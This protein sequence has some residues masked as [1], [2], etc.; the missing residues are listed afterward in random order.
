[1]ISDP[2]LFFSCLMSLL[3]DS[4]ELSTAV[5]ERN[6]LLPKGAFSE[7]IGDNRRAHA[8]MPGASGKFDMVFCPEGGPER[9]PALHVHF[10]KIARTSREAVESAIQKVF[11]PAEF[12]NSKNNK[13]EYVCYSSRRTPTRKIFILFDRAKLPETVSTLSGVFFE[14]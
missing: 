13:G 3:E 10:Q 14:G 7:A 6:L 2:H 11:G 9:G 8:A 5:A 4:E 1:M 12:N